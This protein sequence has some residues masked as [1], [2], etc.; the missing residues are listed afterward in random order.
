M[1]DPP[2]TPL[3]ELEKL[4]SQPTLGED[5]LVEDCLMASKGPQHS[6]SWFS[7]TDLFG[8]LLGIGWGGERLL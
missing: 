8:R 1:R 2:L 4:T 3:P 7:R 5:A 6:R